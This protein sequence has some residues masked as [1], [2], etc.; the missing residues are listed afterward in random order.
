VLFPHVVVLVGAGDADWYTV[1]GEPFHSYE[2]RVNGGIMA[3]SSCSAGCPS[4]ALFDDVGQLVYG[5]MVW[6]DDVSFPS[7]PGSMGLGLSLRWSGGGVRFLRVTG[8]DQLGASGP[9]PSYDVSF[10]DT[11]YSVPRWN[12]SGTQ[13][14]VFVVQNTTSYTVTPKIVLF[15][16]AG[17]VLHTFDLVIGARGVHVQSTAG[18]PI[19]VGKS[20]SALINCDNAGYGALAGK[21]VSVEPSTG[22][23][24]DTPIEPIPY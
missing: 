12:N 20:G 11:S 1:K 10:R 13:V 14:S 15:D 19:L 3:W 9:E 24:F 18:V 7:G 6:D 21:V 23:T 2:A 22:F 4:L 17:T 5:G 16:A 8:S